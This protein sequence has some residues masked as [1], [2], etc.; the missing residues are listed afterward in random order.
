MVLVG[1]AC[2]D[3]NLA[4][5]TAL[6]ISLFDLEL[7]GC[8][9]T[10]EAAAA[11]PTASAGGINTSGDAEACVVVG[12]GGR[13]GVVLVAATAATEICAA[14]GVPTEGGE[15]EGNGV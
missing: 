12:Q 14:A 1:A 9:A 2:I 6:K 10:A 7:E 8:W 11:A 4:A 5:K 13:V 15:G 3:L